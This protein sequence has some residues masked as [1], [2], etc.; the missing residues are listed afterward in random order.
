[1]PSGGQNRSGWQ[2]PGPAGLMAALGAVGLLALLL[3][4][5][6]VYSFWEPAEK[7]ETV[8]RVRYEHTASFDYTVEGE[9]S[10]LYPSGVIGP[11]SPSPGG[12]AG[13]VTPPPIYM[14]LAHSIDLGF[15]Y[16]LEGSPPADVAGDLSAVLQIQGG[17]DGWTRTQ[18]LLPPTPFV[19]RSTSARVDLDLAQVSSLI[20]TVEEET[21]FSAGTYDVSVIPTVRINGSIGGETVEETYAPAFTIKFNRTQ[22]TPDSEL[23]RSEVRTVSETVSQGQEFDLL[24]LSLQVTTA[25]WLSA[26]GA[27]VALAG[28][29]V[30]AA[31]VFLGLGRGEEAKIRARY[32][33]LLV[34]V[35]QADLKE[36]RQKIEVASMQD[37]VR[38]AQRDNRIILHQELERGSHRYFVPDGTV[39][40]EYRVTE[41]AEEA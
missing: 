9:P 13:G 6:T 41:P 18:E 27:A 24:G 4:A 35:A 38:L 14:K 26:A 15:T 2:L 37:L 34:S 5:A 20:E 21:G 3:T 28:A 33:S 36:E 11:I 7:T 23:T 19:G 30:L 25:R 16:A 1:M 31:V 29:A 39:T 22:I 10:T 40:Y 32:G 12:V 8:E 17:E